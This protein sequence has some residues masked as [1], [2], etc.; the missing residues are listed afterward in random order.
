MQLHKASY[1]DA[2]RGSSAESRKTPDD[3]A[4]RGKNGAYDGLAPLQK[5]AHTQDSLASAKQ[6]L[7]TSAVRDGTNLQRWSHH[8]SH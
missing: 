3:I 1:A 7:I 5:V 8:V 6:Y 4:I 2:A